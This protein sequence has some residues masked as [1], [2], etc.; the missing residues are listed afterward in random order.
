MLPTRR[1]EIN[2]AEMRAMSRFDRLL[3]TY[4]YGADVRTR[5]TTLNLGRYNLCVECPEP[6]KFCMCDETL[7]RENIARIRQ[8]AT[9]MMAM[10]DMI[11]YVPGCRNFHFWPIDV[12]RIRYVGYNP[13]KGRP[14]RIAHAPNHA[15]FKGTHYLVAAVER[16]QSEGYAVEM[17]RVQGVPNTEVIALFASCDIVADQFIAGF[18][19][20]TA[21]E[22]MALGKPVLCYLREPSMTIDPETC[23]I[24]NV[25]PATVYEVLKDCVVGRYD[26]ADIGARSRSYVE[27]YYSIEAIALR[28]G[29]LYLDTARFNRRINRRIAKRMAT[30]RSELPPL[31]SGAPPVPWQVVT[32]PVVQEGRA[33][34]L[35]S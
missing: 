3:Y 4:T 20:Y 33:S 25:S 34:L 9:E 10:G 27:H 35:A 29:Q 5:E 6:K 18:H 19:G 7:G 12:G 22:A 31:M 28:L 30:L 2:E 8:Y 16:L 24:I 23:P 1:M 26:L 15:H 14:L 17:F 21:L 11:H 32:D 13:I